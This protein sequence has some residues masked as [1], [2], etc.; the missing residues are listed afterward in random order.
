MAFPFTDASADA[1]AALYTAHVTS[2]G[3]DPGHVVAHSL[4][5]NDLASMCLVFEDEMAGGVSGLLSPDK[6]A[7]V[8][9]EVTQ[10]M[11]H[12]HRAAAVMQARRRDWAASIYDT[13]PA[14]PEA[15]NI[16][17]AFA[18]VNGLEPFPTPAAA[19]DAIV[20]DKD[21]EM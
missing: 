21:L 5:Y 15:W 3:G 11:V 1:T 8:T 18:V 6:K 2:A 10:A 14:A 20:F 9:H 4:A 17:E 13:V 16:R 7:V 19:A 12:M